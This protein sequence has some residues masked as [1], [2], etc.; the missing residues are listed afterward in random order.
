[1]P[2]LIH[3]LDSAPPP[4]HLCQ[5]P[6]YASTPAT[7]ALQSPIL[8]LL[9]PHLILSAAYHDSAPKAP[10]TYASDTS[11][12]CPPS[13]IL[14]LPHPR[15]LPCLCSCRILK[16][17]L[18]HCHPMSSLTHPYASA[19]PQHPQDMP[20]TLPPNVCPHPS[21]H[22]RTPSTYHAYSPTG[23][24][25]Y[26][27]TLNHHVHPD[28]YL[29][30]LT[31]AAYHAYV[32]IAPSRYASDAATQCPPSPILTPALSSLPLTMLMLMY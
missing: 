9:H 22:F 6:K 7:A 3:E 27:P 10:S 26:A 18:Q 23:P 25:I 15:H 17:C 28:P 14:R 8:T 16:I 29:H 12:P 11:P 1:M 21:L 30:F 2:T 20:P 4:S 13:P 19:H 31:P 32:P 24:S 5:P